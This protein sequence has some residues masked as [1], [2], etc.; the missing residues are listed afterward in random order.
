MTLTINA[1]QLRQAIDFLD[2]GD[3]ELEFA[4]MPAGT[5]LSGEPRPAGLYCWFKEYPEEGS[6]LLEESPN[7]AS[8]TP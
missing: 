3:G 5:L 8:E 6:L 7:S 1:Y 2:D 4:W